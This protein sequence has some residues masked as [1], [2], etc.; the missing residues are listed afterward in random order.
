MAQDL[1]IFDLDP[2]SLEPD[3]QHRGTVAQNDCTATVIRDMDG[4]KP[5]KPFGVVPPR[6]AAQMRGHLNVNGPYRSGQKQRRD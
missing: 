4:G 1:N 6:K 5:A 2:V 3:R